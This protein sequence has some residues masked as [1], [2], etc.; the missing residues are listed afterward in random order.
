M[1]LL[2]R[3]LARYGSADGFVVNNRRVAVALPPP[4]APS[5]LFSFWF[6]QGNGAAISGVSEV[7]LVVFNSAGQRVEK[8][9]S[10]T[11][12]RAD[13]GVDAQFLP[14]G[15]YTAWFELGNTTIGYLRTDPFELHILP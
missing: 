14:P 4:N 6:Y 13:F 8:G 7:T 12:N 2:N 11:Q 3:L 9:F 5:G 15:V 1:Q 10:L